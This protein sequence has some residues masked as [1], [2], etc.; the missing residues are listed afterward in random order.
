[1]VTQNKLNS[2]INSRLENIDVQDLQNNQQLEEYKF[3]SSI[4]TVM[5]ITDEKYYN[6]GKSIKII[7][8]ESGLYT[9]IKSED[10]QCVPGQIV[11]NSMRWYYETENTKV[12]GMRFNTVTHFYDAD[13]KE[14]TY[15]KST[16]D[17]AS[18]NA[19]NSTYNEWNRP[20]QFEKV[21]VPPRAVKY[22]V[23]YVI[24]PQRERKCVFNRFLY[25]SSINK[26]DEKNVK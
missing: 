17:Y 7:V 19:A 20:Y 5:S 16:L 9:T 13:E 21:I 14:I 12:G 1:M 2:K 26:K 25:N 4:S 6:D 11:I 18:V 24:N 22:S 10:I 15:T 3:A 8:P 23:T